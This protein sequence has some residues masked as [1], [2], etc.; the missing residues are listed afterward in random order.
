M[1]ETTVTVRQINGRWT[2]GQNNRVHKT[3]MRDKTVRG[4]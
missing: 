3:M 2:E 1:T 4:T